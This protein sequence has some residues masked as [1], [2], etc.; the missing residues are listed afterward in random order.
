[1]ALRAGLP[2][3]ASDH[4][5]VEEI[6]SP[7][8]SRIVGY[9]AP[10]MLWSPWRGASRRASRG[11]AAALRELL[12]DPVELERMGCRAREAGERMSFADT[13]DRLADAALALATGPS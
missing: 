5:G 9:D 13:S 6:L 4:S 3:L 2:I 10:A 11:L 1:E 8:F 7:G 12:G